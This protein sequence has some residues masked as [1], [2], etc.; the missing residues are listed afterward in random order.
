MECG[1]RG[2]EE[3][4]MEKKKLNEKKNIHCV[5]GLLIEILFIKRPFS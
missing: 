5:G 3:D 4:E 1:L 2:E